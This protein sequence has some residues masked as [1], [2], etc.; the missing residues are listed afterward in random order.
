MT[1]LTKQLLVAALIAAVV[2]AII[3]TAAYY[4]SQ[5]QPIDTSDIPLW[6]FI[7]GAR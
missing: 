7:G 4:V 6:A 5:P 3:L 2:I 1:T